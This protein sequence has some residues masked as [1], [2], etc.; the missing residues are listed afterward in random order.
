MENIVIFQF[1]IVSHYINLFIVNHYIKCKQSTNYYKAPVRVMYTRNWRSP[2]LF[3]FLKTLNINED[4]EVLLTANCSTL[5]LKFKSYVC[6]EGRS[7]EGKRGQKQ[8]KHGSN[9]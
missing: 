4:T 7:V 5:Y 2:Q 9:E 3:T 1:L 8:R 6:V